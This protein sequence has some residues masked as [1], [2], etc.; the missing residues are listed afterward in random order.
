MNFLGFEIGKI[1]NNDRVGKTFVQPTYEDGAVEVEQDNYSSYAANLGYSF[2]L[3]AVPESDYELTM[4]YRNLSIQ[5]DVDEA[6]Q[7]I[8]NEAIITDDFKDTVAII[9]DDVD[10]SDN[11]K[12][13]IKEEF[14]YILRL[15]DFKN[16]GYGL[17]R[18]WYVDGRLYFHK[19]ITT[20]TAKTIGISEVMPID[21]L[22]IK[23][24]REYKVDRNKEMGMQN[25]MEMDVFNLDEIE[26][27]YIYS[28]VPFTSNNHQD[29]RNGARIPTESISSSQSGL[30]SANG[31]QVLSYLYKS[32]KPYNNLK[33]LEDSV[34]I[35]RVTRAPERRIFYVDVGS[36]PKGKADQYMKD[37]MNRFKNKIVYDVNKGTINNRK[38]F[39]SMI[40]DY[41]LP[42]REGGR[43][44][45]VTT[46]PGG[47]QLGEL[48]DVEYFKTKLYKSLG[49]PLSR[50]QG[51]STAF[52][53]G[54]TTEIT[55]DEIKF[56]KYIK[57]LRKKFATIFDDLLKTQLL[58]KTIITKKEWT[59]ATPK[60]TYAF[61]EDNYFSEMK[62][63][64]LMNDRVSMLSTMTQAE[65]IGKYYSHEYIRREILKQSEDE[66]KAMDEQIVNEKDSKQYNP[67]EADDMSG[68][69]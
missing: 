29:K 39:Q 3:D 6:I 69:F 34:V 21:P 14:N 15:L 64:E 4:A 12:L 42:R 1:K 51:D 43:G 2:D 16:N 35:Y 20:K 31:K 58:L 8:I 27:Y 18:K 59:E 62:E 60:I 37:V 49:V 54:R 68:G 24:I 48:S 63:V 55:R 65:I 19:V 17:F 9:L 5:P 13:K 56:N 33:L 36:L 30:L 47:E 53:I 23:L 66:I 25:V 40:E 7:E 32:I 61:L 44:T 67:G 45:E 10:L 41:W 50:F 22:N 38:K 52:N 11:I 26:E 28:R 46:L 57:R